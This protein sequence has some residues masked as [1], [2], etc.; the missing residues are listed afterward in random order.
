MASVCAK[1]NS[2]PSE[3]YVQGWRRTLYARYKKIPPKGFFRC[4]L[5]SL[6]LVMKYRGICGSL[7]MGI[8]ILSI[9]KESRDIG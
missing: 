8:Y 9:G 5:E 4:D 3:G 1:N 6:V 7:V 2:S